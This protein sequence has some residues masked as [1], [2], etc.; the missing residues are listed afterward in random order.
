MESEFDR[1]TVLAGVPIRAIE[2]AFEDGSLPGYFLEIDDRLRPMLMVVGG[3]GTFREDLYYYGGLPG[4]RRGY[5]VLMVDLPGQGRNPARGF[6]FRHDASSAV[7]G[8]LDWYE[9]NAQAPDPRVAAYGLSGG[10][11]FTAQAVSADPRIQAWIASTPIFDVGLVFSREMRGVG[12][13]PGWLV[14]LGA[15]VLGRT[16][17]VV[18]VALKKY[19]WQFGVVDF[20]EV[21]ARVS[22]EAPIVDPETIVCP[23]LFL[24]GDGDA[25]ELRRQTNQLADVMRTHGRD[26][27]VRRFSREEGDAHCQVTNLELAHLVVFDWLD[28]RFNNSSSGPH[29]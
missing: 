5:N 28:R 2:V 8:C 12:R 26:V 9:A 23:S 21:L 27:T 22:A 29:R 25:D 4:W 20:A 19:A 16:N 18:D 3:G 13:A 11:Y 17:A 15:K 24:V 10:G 6:P 1:A 7:T 14:K